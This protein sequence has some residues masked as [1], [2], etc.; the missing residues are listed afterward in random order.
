MNKFNFFTRNYRKIVEM[1]L[2]CVMILIFV[3]VS[4][5]SIGFGYINYKKMKKYSAA[6]SQQI[7]YP[8]TIQLCQADVNGSVSCDG[9]YQT[10]EEAR[11]A[12]QLAKI[13]QPYTKFWLNVC[14]KECVASNIYL[15]D[16]VK[17]VFTKTV[18]EELLKQQ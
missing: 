11:K 15:P 14:H 10:L 6:Q 17:I 1:I 9:G 13:D 12:E 3:F 4:V 7:Y 2:L 5:W 8:N 16:G 18:L